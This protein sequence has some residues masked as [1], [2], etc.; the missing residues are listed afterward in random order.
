LQPEIQSRNL[1]RSAPRP[2]KFR[3]F[4]LPI[5]VYVVSGLA[6]LNFYRYQ[7]DPDG[8]SY[9]SIAQKYACGDF[10]DAING[11]WGPMTSWFLVPFLVVGVPPLVSAKL[12]SLCIGCLTIISFKSFSYRFHMSEK[13]RRTTLLVTIPVVLQFA[14]WIFTPDLLLT[15]VLLTYFSIIF[16]MDYPAH[17]FHGALCGGI[18]AIAYLAKSSAFPFFLLHFLLLSGLHYRGALTKGRKSKVL[19][20]FLLGLAAFVALSTPWVSIISKKYGNTTIGTAGRYNWQMAGPESKG[21]AHFYQGF[22]KP[23]NQSAISGWE[24]PSYIRTTPWSPFD[25]WRN[26]LHE[27]RLVLRNVYAI[28]MAFESFSFLSMAII[29]GFIVSCAAPPSRVSL[30]G[31]ALFA[32]LTILLYAGGYTPFLVRSRHLFVLC[33]LLVAMGGS[34]LDKLFSSDF[35]TQ[36]RRK[37]TIC[38]FVVSFVGAPTAQL[39]RDINVG[40]DIYELNRRLQETCMIKGNVASYNNWRESLYLSFHLNVRYYGVPKPGIA[41]PDLEMELKRNDIDYFLV[42]DRAWE[43]IGFLSDYQEVTEGTLRGLHVYYMGN[44]EKRQGSSLE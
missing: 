44:G 11:Y 33:L 2:E 15:C 3:G 9:I 30:R 14:V 38:F 13:V 35:F 7:L 28:V 32:L 40:K 23:P 19:L 21:Q 22:I 43:D 41:D 31:G 10:H 12:L 39:L 37:I 6:F 4:L 16:R 26:F 5:I 29:L 36:A 42:W 27:L 1:K 17:L 25:S 34:L 24:D 8:I 18:G 20:S